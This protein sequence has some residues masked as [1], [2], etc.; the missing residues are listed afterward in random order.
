MKVEDLRSR[1]SGGAG[2]LFEIGSKHH[3][4]RATMP[5]RCQHRRGPHGLA[6]PQS[7]RHNANAVIASRKNQISAWVMIRRRPAAAGITAPIGNH[8]FRETG[9][10]AYLAQWR[11]S[12]ERA[13]GNGDAGESA[14]DQAL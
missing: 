11:R 1:G 7:A 3:T 14:H 2:R 12:L 5:G 6:V 9:I 10:T 13:Q 4:S 8:T